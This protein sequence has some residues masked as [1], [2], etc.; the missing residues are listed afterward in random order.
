MRHPTRRSTAFTLVELAIVIAIMMVLAAL[1]LPSLHHAIVRSKRAEAVTNVDGIDVALVAY[2]TAVGEPPPDPTGLTYPDETTLGRAAQPWAPT[3]AEWPLGT[4]WAPTGDVRC[5][6]H[7]QVGLGQLALF[8]V[9]DTDD[10][11]LFYVD[12]R[13][14]ALDSLYDVAGGSH[15]CSALY[16]SCVPSTECY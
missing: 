6:Y 1:A 9:C 11:D 14:V 10:D 7:H 15:C 12:M 4:G 3:D 13:T 2:I 16:S 8:G 5:G